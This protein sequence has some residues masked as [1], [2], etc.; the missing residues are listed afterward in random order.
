[1]MRGIGERLIDMPLNIRVKRDH[2]ANGHAFLLTEA[3]LW[4]AARVPLVA[5]SR[6]G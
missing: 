5:D 6:R 2:L 4:I 1:M 3:N